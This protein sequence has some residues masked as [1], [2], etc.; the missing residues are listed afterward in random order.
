MKKLTRI[1]LP[2]FLSLIQAGCQCSHEWSKANRITPQACAKCCEEGQVPLGHQWSETSCSADQVC[3]QCAV[4]GS[5]ALDHSFGP[6]FFSDTTMT[7]NCA[8]CGFPE[9]TQIDRTM[10]YR[11]DEEML[12]FRI[13]DSN[14]QDPFY[15][16]FPMKRT[17]SY[18][19]KHAFPPFKIFVP[20]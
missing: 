18:G 6:W 5:P 10:Y 4:P 12:T 14:N 3:L 1:L 13:Y 16:M 7:H 8:L 20:I 15:Q 9:T 19:G 11:P 2:L 17:I